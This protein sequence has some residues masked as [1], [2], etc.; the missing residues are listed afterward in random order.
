MTLPAHLSEL[1]AQIINA[2][3]HRLNAAATLHNKGLDANEYHRAMALLHKIG[4]DLTDAALGEDDV[5]LPPAPTA[6]S[7]GG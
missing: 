3:D 2:L 7:Q 6:E 1:R 4:A 5:P